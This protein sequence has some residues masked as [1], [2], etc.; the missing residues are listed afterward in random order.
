M[1]GVNTAVCTRSLGRARW[2]LLALVCA[3]VLAGCSGG[4]T[5]G[6]TGPLPFALPTFGAT[7]PGKPVDVYVRLARL[8]KSCWMTAPAPLGRGFL[9]T[10]DMS[11]ETKGGAGSIVIYQ[12]KVSCCT[13][14]PSRSLSR[15]FA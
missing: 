13:Q 6:S 1:A 10:A 9:F 8:A 11:P 15:L 3:A 12:R 4:P 2:R 14:S 5:G 7:T